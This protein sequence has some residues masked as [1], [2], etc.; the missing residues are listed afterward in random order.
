M[1]VTKNTTTHERPADVIEGLP[2]GPSIAMNQGHFLVNLVTNIGNFIMT[3]VIGLWMTPYLIHHLGVTGYGLIPLITG[4]ISYLSVFTLSINASVGRFVTLLMERGEAEPANRVFN[5]A[6]FC[7]VAILLFL[8]PAGVWTV[9]HV[10]MFLVIPAG[11]ERQ[12]HWLFICALT[13]FMLTQLASPFEIASYC[14]NRF[15]L[16]NGIAILTLLIRVGAIVFLFH[17]SSPRIWHVGIGYLLAALVTVIG[18]V[19]VWRIL[20]PQLSIAPLLFDWAVLKELV[21]MGGWVVVNYI[22]S[23]LFLGVD[24]I[25]A[26]RLLG[27]QAAGRYTTVLQWSVLLRLMAGTVAAVFGPSVL[28]YYARQDHG[29]LVSYLCRAVKFMGLAL[30]LPIGLICGFAQPLLSLWVGKAFVPLAGLMMLMTIHLCIN[31]ATLPLISLQ[32]ATKR[33]RLPGIVTCIG[34]M[35]NLG[36][37]VLLAGPV[38]WGMYGIAVAG[39]LLFTANYSV[40]TPIY[41]ARILGHHWGLFFREMLPTLMATLLVGGAAWL[42]AASGLVTSWAALIIA[43]CGIALAYIAIVYSLGLSVAEREMVVAMLP[44]KLRRLVR[45]P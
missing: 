9:S 18:A 22:G 21:G 28:Y 16:R 5:T 11:Y 17:L 33:V 29:G 23:V 7:I 32:I 1:A 25:I 27:P 40:F 42:L 34:G 38:G 10:R 24:L 39:A 4:V 12:V 15:D 35:L 3:I 6:L 14:R 36:L 2:T 26:N 20:L 37:A 8:L 30:A 31:L 19:V 13:V 41:S 45:S 44:T 43:G